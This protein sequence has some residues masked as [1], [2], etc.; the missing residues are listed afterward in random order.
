MRAAL[1][2]LLIVGAIVARQYGLRQYSAG[3]KAGHDAGLEAAR[4]SAPVWGVALHD[5][6]PG[7]PVHLALL[8][9][10]GYVAGSGS[11]SV[12]VLGKP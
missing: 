3:Y 4:D 10:G 7:E 2:V 1:L 9:P 5:A 8:R 11:V 6:E 12:S